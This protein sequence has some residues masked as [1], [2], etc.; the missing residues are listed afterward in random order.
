MI[1]K[2]GQNFLIDENIA[3]REVEYADINSNDIVLEIGP[4]KGILTNIIANRAKKVI[5]V[6]LDT[7][8]FYNL[9]K[10]CP[11]NVL[12]LNDDILKIDLNDLPRFNKIVSNLPFQISSPVT[13]KILKYNFSIGIFIYQ[14]EFAQRL[15]ANY[16]SKHYSRLSVNVF[17]KA[18]CQYLE[19]ISK[20][21]FSPMPK[22]ESAIVK[23]VPRK[24][25]PFKVYDEE[26][27]YN[28]VKNLFNHKRKKIKTTV[29]QL[30]KIDREK[31]PF[32]DNRVED[33]SPEQIG[34]LS[35]I[36]FNLLNE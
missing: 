2:I 18:N 27:F 32:S 11:D 13:F 8:L 24:N 4:G 20:Y 1:K 7:S 22:V 35:N 5:A 29:K 9:K 28:F 3:R 26:F 23:L 17:F 12:L 6:E 33:L 19:T 21:C 34:Y 30:Y 15:V 31:I 25:P 14:K 36:L 10:T 16:G